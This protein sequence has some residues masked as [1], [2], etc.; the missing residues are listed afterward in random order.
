MVEL[1]EKLMERLG[2]KFKK[3]SLTDRE[4]ETKELILAM[5][6]ELIELLNWTNWKNWKKTK[7]K[8]DHMEI[9]FEIVDLFHFLIE[10]AVVWGMSA[11]D[12]YHHFLAK[13]KENH[14]RQDKGY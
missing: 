4:K 8:V 5:Q 7:K 12:I 13:N 6:A 14:V 1:Q 11:D 9:R 10:I 2:I 3:M